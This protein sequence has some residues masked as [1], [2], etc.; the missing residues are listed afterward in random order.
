LKK[1]QVEIFENSLKPDI[2]V[3]GNNPNTCGIE[4]ISYPIVLGNTT[5]PIRE[6]DVVHYLSKKTELSHKKKLKRIYQSFL[7][8]H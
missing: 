3:W 5:I 6:K 7:E 2:Q 4:I 8:L 1:S